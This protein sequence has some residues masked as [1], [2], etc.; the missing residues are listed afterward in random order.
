MPEVREQDAALALISFPL[1]DERKSGVLFPNFGHSSTNGYQL[2]VPYYFN[3]APNYDLT[4]TPG[5]LSAR[6]VQL[7]EEF[8]YLT[9]RSHG[10][11]DGNFLPGDRQA[12]SD[13]TYF[14]AA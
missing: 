10:V 4:L 6:G 3:L 5:L 12:H 8:R 1:G 11:I 7:G 9:K 2:E 13:R 14:H